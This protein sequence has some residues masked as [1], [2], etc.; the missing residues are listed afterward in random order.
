MYYKMIHYTGVAKQ[1]ERQNNQRVNTFCGKIVVVMVMEN[2]IPL[3][4]FPYMAPELYKI[5]LN[6][7]EADGW[8]YS[9]AMATIIHKYKCFKTQISYHSLLT[10]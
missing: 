8:C 5:I 3:G 10:P 2:M 9:V 1:L 7:F 4:T 6:N